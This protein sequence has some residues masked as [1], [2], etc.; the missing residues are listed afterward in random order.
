MQLKAAQTVNILAINNLQQRVMQFNDML[1]ETRFYE[2]ED[3]LHDRA[4]ELPDVY[5]DTYA[6]VKGM[7]NIFRVGLGDIESFIEE[8]VSQ[9]SRP[10][11]RINDNLDSLPEPKSENKTNIRPQSEQ[12]IRS[13]PQTP[14]EWDGDAQNPS[15]NPPQRRATPQI[16]GVKKKS[17]IPPPLTP[18]PK[19]KPQ[20]RPTV[21]HADSVPYHSVLRAPGISKE[22]FAAA[23]HS[24]V[25]SYNEGL[26]KNKVNL[27]GFRMDTFWKAV[28][29]GRNLRTESGE[30]VKYALYVKDPVFKYIRGFLQETE[31][32]L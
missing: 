10:M 8:H 27:P 11:K 14:P 30:T 23:Y 17:E 18:P 29:H 31:T 28:E 5:E 24:L 1:R 12:L 4:A 15:Y 2:L 26:E 21:K 3:E 6:T 16:G 22:Y 19:K 20:K 25:Q 7:A 9:Y 13:R 32:E